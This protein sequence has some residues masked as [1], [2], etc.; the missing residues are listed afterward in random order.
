[1][2]SSAEPRRLAQKRLLFALLT[3]ALVLV[4]IEVSAAL[5][6]WILG[7]RSAVQAGG[8]AEVIVSIPGA[9]IERFRWEHYDSQLGWDLRPYYHAT[10]S[11]DW[12]Y[13]IDHRGARNSD[14][15]PGA[16]RIASYGDSFTFGNQVD[17]HQT[18]PA[19]LSGLAQTR[20][21][22]YGVP[23]YGTYLAMM[24]HNLDALA[25]VFGDIPAT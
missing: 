24:Q 2:V 9:E 22:N 21:L 23:G 5:A 10:R 25:A 3:A 18:Y 1:M 14:E 13:R 8:W 16:D 12:S 19:I 15:W 4:T 7:P 20:V 17:D 11:P 6:L